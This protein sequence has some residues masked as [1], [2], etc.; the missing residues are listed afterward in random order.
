MSRQNLQ[1]RLQ[2]VADSR[3]F[4]KELVERFG[5]WLLTPPDDA[6]YRI[7]PLSWAKEHA[8]D[9]PTATDLFLHAAHAGLL[10]LIWALA[11]SQ[12]GLLIRTPG[13]LKSL[14]RSALCKL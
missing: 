12:C 7:K 1:L 13:A 11:C 5:E 8:I 6:G 9:E 3:K 14:H 10:D 4:T 2:I